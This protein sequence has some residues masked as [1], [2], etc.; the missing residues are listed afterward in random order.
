MKKWDLQNEYG[1]SF[2]LLARTL[3]PKTPSD[4]FYFIVLKI[5]Y[6]PLL[7][8]HH[9]ICLSSLHFLLYSC[10]SQNLNSLDLQKYGSVISHPNDS[11]DHIL[12]LLYLFI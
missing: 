9:E 10:F 6:Y 2:S 8:N 3:T 4:F 1:Y 7:E 5:H 12:H 11:L